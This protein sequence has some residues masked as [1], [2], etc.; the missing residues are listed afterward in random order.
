[1]FS[2]RLFFSFIP[3]LGTL[4]AIWVMWD[5]DVDENKA[6]EISAELAKRKAPKP[7]GNSAENKVS[8]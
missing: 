6:R 4:T 2:L 7:S 8:E 3:L 5:Y 1:M